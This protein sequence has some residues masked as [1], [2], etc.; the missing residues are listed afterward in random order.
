M[1]KTNLLESIKEVKAQLPNLTD[2][3]LKEFH[4]IVEKEMEKRKL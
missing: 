4:D 2:K 3:L 1:G